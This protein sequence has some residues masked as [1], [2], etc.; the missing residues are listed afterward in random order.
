MNPDRFYAQLPVIQIP[1]QREMCFRWLTE[2]DLPALQKI[3]SQ[4]Q[5]VRF[6][7]TEPQQDE[8]QARAYLQSIRDGFASGDL[9]QWGLE[10]RGDI[11]GTST[12]AGIE[13]DNHHAEIGFALSP[14]YWGKGLMRRAIPAVLGFAFERLGLRRIT[15][16]VDPRNTPSLRLLAALGF[17]EE[18][19]LR[20]RYE[21]MGEIQDALILGLLRDDWTRDNGF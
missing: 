4:P 17:Q 2:N 1:D 6:M 11:V 10:Y 20:Q 13:R 7:S 9:Y 12:L 15:A 3:F 18:G 19:L 5:V 21:H 14:E 8:S 16:D